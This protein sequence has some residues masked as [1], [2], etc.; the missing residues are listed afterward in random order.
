MKLLKGLAWG[1]IIE[2]AAVGVFVAAEAVQGTRWV[3]PFLAMVALPVLAFSF[4]EK[5]KRR[6]YR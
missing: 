2:A 1:L 5:P 3:F 4:P 6:R